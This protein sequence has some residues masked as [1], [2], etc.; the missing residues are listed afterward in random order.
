MGFRV[1]NC[2]RAEGGWRLLEIVPD[3]ELVNGVVESPPQADQFVDA[4]VLVA[5]ESDGS[6]GVEGGH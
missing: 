1:D 5:A 2:Q 4:G 6:R 3:R